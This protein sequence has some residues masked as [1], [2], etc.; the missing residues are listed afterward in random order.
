MYKRAV[1]E[2]PK[3]SG[4]AIKEKWNMTRDTEW[5]MWREGIEEVFTVDREK[6]KTKLYNNKGEK[7]WP[8][9]GEGEE[10]EQKEVSEKVKAQTMVCGQENEKE[11][12]IRNLFY[13][14]NNDI[15]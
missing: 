10:A 11:F 6:P 15:F 2:K 8:G 5:K 13:R 7:W 14:L 9:G 12:P 4:T 3:P 1:F